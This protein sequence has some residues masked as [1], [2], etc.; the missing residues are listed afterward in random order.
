MTSTR[1]TYAVAPTLPRIEPSEFVT[2]QDRLR[3]LS[4]ERGLGAVLA[5]SR[6]AT[7][8]DQYADVYYLS[9]FYSHYP[10]VPD[11]A[12]R[13][14]AKG[15]V[16]LIL[17]TEGRSSLV[18]D[19]AS[20]RED[21][22]VADRL[23]TNQ[24]VIA[25]AAQA[26]RQDVD[27]EAPIG[28]LG[29]AALGWQWLRA[30][31]SELGHR[32]VAAD[33]LGPALRVIKSPGEQDL[34]RAAGRVG[35]RAVEAAMDTAQPGKT[36]AQVAAAA[37]QAV[38]DAGAMVY[39][40]SL[41]TGPYASMYAQS[42]PAPFDSRYVLKAGDMARIDMYGSVDGYLFDFGRARVVGAAPTDEQQMLIDAAR[43][44]VTAGIAAIRLGGTLGDIAR[45]ADY[46][47][48]ESALTRSGKALAPEFDSWGH[49]LGLN[50]EAPYI[51]A[52]SEVVIEAGMCLAVEKRTAVPGIGGATY[53]DNVLITADGVELLSD[54]RTAYGECNGP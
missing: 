43:D 47:L 51:D 19:L 48:A 50:W 37:F 17:P 39:G 16:G 40:I 11:A 10:A 33:D 54:A 45:A 1:S 3:V 30:L 44:S 26:I 27:P 52:D 12:E 53:E 35:V 42:Q 36:E 41:S 46:A 13:W 49:S 15:C 31:E 25:A 22:L 23:L 18:T 4:G 8:Q 34:L 20:Y 28:V 7:T 24:D 29:S 5:W 14:R 6:G 9:N 21:L 32:F 38:V 2:R